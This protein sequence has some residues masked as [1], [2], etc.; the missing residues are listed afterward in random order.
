MSD[1]ILTAGEIKSIRNATSWKFVR[2]ICD[3]ALELFEENK[4]QD[5]VID[6]LR[7]KII[8][9]DGLLLRVMAERDKLQDEVDGYE[10]G[11]RG[12]P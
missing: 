11:Y 1:K 6:E 4:S 3:T 12:F 8:S 10:L 5:R 9:L 7:N 2:D